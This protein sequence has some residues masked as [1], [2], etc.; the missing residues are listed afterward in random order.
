M[1]AIII[2]NPMLW[3]NLCIPFGVGL[4]LLLTN[5]SYN[6]K[7]FG[8]QMGVTIFVLFVA[9]LILFGAT[10]NLIS[11]VYYNSKVTQITYYEEWTELVHYTEQQ[12]SGSGTKKICT[13][14]YK[15]RKDYHSPYW[16]ITSSSGNTLSI[17]SGEFKQAEQKYGSRFTSVYHS[18][19]C[20]Y[21]D[22]NSYVVSPTEIIPFVSSSEE[23]NY[24]K[25]VNNIARADTLPQKIEMYKKQGQLLEYPS[26]M[27]GEY[28]S[29]TI[30]RVLVAKGVLVSTS[31]LD[32]KIQDFASDVGS[33]KQINPMIYIVSGQ[34]REFVSV[35]KAYWVNG[36][37]NDSILVLNVDKN[38]IVEWSDVIAWTKNTNFLVDNTK[39]YKGLNINDPQLFELYY[40]Q[41]M[42]NWVRTPMKEFKYL[43]SNIDLSFTIEL[44]LILVNLILSVVAFWFFMN[45]ETFGARKQSFDS[46]VSRNNLRKW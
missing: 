6:I 44:S 28:G 22:G 4:F 8:V 42:R 30:Q 27:M 13:T 19:K 45:S 25:A 3:V 41:I 31:K 10:T 40:N 9:Y 37:K 29:R 15:T 7:E 20:S 26:L 5:N 17:E 14:I 16:E 46:Y 34:N 36:A 39:I 32:R 43:S 18:G 38:G 21:G 33:F 23:V 2:Q 35:L 24:V 11:K 12:C 1:F